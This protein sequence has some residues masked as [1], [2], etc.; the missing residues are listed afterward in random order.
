MQV[1]LP[2]LFGPISACTVPGSTAKDTP[3]SAAIPPNRTVRSSTDEPLGR[4][5]GRDRRFGDD[6]VGRADRD[7]DPEVALPDVVA[8][9]EFLGRC[10]TR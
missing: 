8:G 9:R 5:G 6:D 1:D 7:G 4:L 2:A 3:A 10:P